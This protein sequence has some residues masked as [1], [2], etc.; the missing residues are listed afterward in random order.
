[1]QLTVDGDWVPDYP[2]PSS[3][4]PQLLGCHGGN[5]R[6]AYFCDPILDRRMQRASALELADPPRAQALW[7]AI[8]HE[9]VDRAVWVPTVNVGNTVLVSRRLRNVEYHPLWGFMAAQAWVD[10]KAGRARN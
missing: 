6:K 10:Q 8:D 4:L 7:A 9:L 3:Y 5:N 2:A 1:M